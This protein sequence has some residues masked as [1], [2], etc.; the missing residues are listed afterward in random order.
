MLPFH[1]PN[2]VVSLIEDSLDEYEK[3]IQTLNFHLKNL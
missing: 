3:D 2:E 1:L